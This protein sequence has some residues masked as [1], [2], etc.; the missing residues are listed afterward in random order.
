MSSSKSFHTYQ[1]YLAKWTENDQKAAEYIKESK[2]NVIASFYNE[3]NFTKGELPLYVTACA[4]HP[5][6]SRCKLYPKH[7][8]HIVAMCKEVE[9]FLQS[10]G[11]PYRLNRAATGFT[12][13]GIWPIRCKFDLKQ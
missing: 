4:T 12:H 13:S 1:D 7:T 10:N 6:E 2:H 3:L 5:V 9:A 11:F 8:Q